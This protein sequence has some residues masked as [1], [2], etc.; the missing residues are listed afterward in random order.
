MTTEIQPLDY[1]VQAGFQ[2]RF[3]QTF[4]AVKCAY[5]DVNDKIRI[6]QR[7]FGEGNQVQYPYAYLVVTRLAVN[8]HS[9]N[10]GYLSRRGIVINVSAKDTYQTVR[11]LPADFEIECT[12]ITNK[13]Q[14]VEQGSVMSFARRWLMARRNG[15]L[16]FSID[17]GKKQFGVGVTMDE[18]VDIPIRENITEAETSMEITV[19]A[20]VHGYVSEPVLGEKGRINK[21]NVNNFEASI[22]PPNQVVVSTQTFTFPDR[23]TS[24]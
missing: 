7:V 2:Q 15:Y 18:A 14:A 16:K 12:Y 24:E 5:V 9:Y 19:R 23:I 13:F 22:Y 6:I 10:P 3:Q 4:G 8:E 17:Y 20:T 1:F 11:I 21:L